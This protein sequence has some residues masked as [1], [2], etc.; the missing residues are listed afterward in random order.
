M[1]TKLAHS[2]REEGRVRAYRCGGSV[3]GC[4]G[5]LPAL[6][7]AEVTQIVARRLREERLQRTIFTP[8]R[9]TTSEAATASVDVAGSATKGCIDGRQRTLDAS[10][11][12]ASEI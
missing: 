12:A 1:A 7:T 9:G 4:P 3:A 10:D 5:P 6:L 2:S 11:A 8:T